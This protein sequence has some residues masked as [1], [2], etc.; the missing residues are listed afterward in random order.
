MQVG[1][2]VHAST[3]AKPRTPKLLGS[4]RSRQMVGELFDG[5][6]RLVSYQCAPATLVSHHWAPFCDRAEPAPSSAAVSHAHAHGVCHGTKVAKGPE[7][8]DGAMMVAITAAQ[9]T[10]HGEDNY[11]CGV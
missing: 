1:G 10:G 7:K 4:I 5:P 2:T 11:V 6:A 8:W 3:A 9:R